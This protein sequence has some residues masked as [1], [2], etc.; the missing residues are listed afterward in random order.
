MSQRRDIIGAQTKAARQSIAA[1]RATK[2]NK[3]S[4]SYA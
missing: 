1:P 2:Q 3:E 4:S